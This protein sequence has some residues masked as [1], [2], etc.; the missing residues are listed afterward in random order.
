MKYF[1]NNYKLW[2]FYYIVFYFLIIVLPERPADVVLWKYYFPF[3]TMVL[4]M[5]IW[6]ANAHDELILVH[7]GKAYSNKRILVIVFG[8]TTVLIIFSTLLCWFIK[9]VTGID[10]SFLITNV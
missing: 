8:S 7:K 1:T 6:F 2:I 5:T 3:K 10:L 9:E 4:T